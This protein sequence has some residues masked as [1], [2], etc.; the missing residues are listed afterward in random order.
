M[1]KAKAPLKVVITYEPAPDWEDR[2][3]RTYDIVLLAGARRRL[4]AEGPVL[5]INDDEHLQESGGGQH[6]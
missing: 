1:T 6:G 4:E 3:H 2:L 5:K